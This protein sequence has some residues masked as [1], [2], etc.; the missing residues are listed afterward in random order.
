[1]SIGTMVGNESNCNVQVTFIRNMLAIELYYIQYIDIHSPTTT[2]AID[3]HVHIE[4]M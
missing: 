3:T 2:S 4:T 1:M